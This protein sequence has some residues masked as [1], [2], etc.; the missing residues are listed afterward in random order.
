MLSVED[1]RKQARTRFQRNWHNW[2]G[3]WFAGDECTPELSASLHPPK[4]ADL[5]TSEQVARARA[6]V[7]SW[8]SCELPGVE[9]QRK[10]WARVGDQV[11]PARVHLAG[12]EQIAQWAGCSSN[13]QTAIDRMADVKA[14]MEDWRRELDRK[15]GGDSDVRDIDV[16][17]RSCIDTWCALD[18][19]DWKKTLLVWS[20]L[21]AHPGE[22]RYVRQ[23]PIRGI[24]T[25]WAEHHGKAL[26]GL[27]RALTG[28]G[29]SFARPQTLFRCKACCP[30]TT[31]DGCREF[32]LPAAQ[33][34]EIG[35]RPET[36]LICEN[37][38][39]TLC[40]DNLP[41]TLG[42][43]GAGFAVTELQ[44]VEWLSEV[45]VL[46]W[47]DLDS[48]GFAILNALR[49]FA[50]HV[51]SVMMDAATLNRHFDL[52]VEEPKAALG[53]LEN[54]TQSERDA[55]EILRCGDA[56]RGIHNLR[57]EQE[58]IEWDWA[59]SQIRSAL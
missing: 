8:R 37:L 26:Q 1:V 38:V 27:Y 5:T 52:C 44:Q 25:K 58:R 3:S 40:L 16:A 12:V 59:C 17:V 4:E 46:Y 41:G 34:N 23:L 54:L 28:T 10:S 43:H 18:E 19:A 50:P 29:F 6:W 7:A 57:L 35:F 24:D 22:T 45:P 32:A 42:L 39:S 49:S 15:A 55:L 20:W 31:L 51:R 14:H 2:A 36:L 11:L 21:F 13:W 9:W 48:N 47:G 33:L 53:S 30:E 56:A